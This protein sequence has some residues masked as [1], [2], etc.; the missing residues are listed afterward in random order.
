MSVIAPA[1]KGNIPI[2]HYVPLSEFPGGNPGVVA[3]VARPTFRSNRSTS[4]LINKPSR[5][6]AIPGLSSAGQGRTSTIAEAITFV[7]RLWCIFG[8]EGLGA[9]VLEGHYNIL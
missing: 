1:G 4:A 9:A 2:R 3:E 8:H 7:D 6:T 5:L